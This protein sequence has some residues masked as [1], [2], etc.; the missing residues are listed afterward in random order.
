M[1]LVKQVVFTG[2]HNT[3][4]EFT[5]ADLEGG[6]FYIK[7]LKS[8]PPN[9]KSPH[10]QFLEQVCWATAVTGKSNHPKDTNLLTHPCA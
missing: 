5:V 10:F 3:H 7:E 9:W 6:A 4:Q 8:C 1:D 2:R